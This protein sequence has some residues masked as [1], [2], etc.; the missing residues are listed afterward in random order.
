MVLFFIP[1]SVPDS[2]AIGAM[3]R[4]AV[5]VSIQFLYLLS[6]SKTANYVPCFHVS[7]SLRA[8]AVIYHINGLQRILELKK[9]NV[10]EVE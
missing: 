2:E 3:L 10:S 1:E 7:P 5:T 4:G 6:A 9:T 8:N